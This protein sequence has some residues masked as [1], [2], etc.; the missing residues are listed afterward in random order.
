M[1]TENHLETLD[2]KY[3]LTAWGLLFVWWGLR[4]S[5]LYV[6][7]EGFGLLGSGVILLGLN[8]LRALKGIPTARITSEFGLIA[9]ILGGTIYLVTGVL[10]FG[11]EVPL[12]ESLL[13]AVGVLFF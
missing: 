4:W 3:E 5:L 13:I 2:R 12:F 10:H 7:P 9:L 6:L 11:G 8:A 1:N